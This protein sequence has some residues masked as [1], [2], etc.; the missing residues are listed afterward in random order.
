[1]Q[2]HF[3]RVQKSS[4]SQFSEAMRGSSY[5]YDKCEG[6]EQHDFLEEAR[7]MVAEREAAKGNAIMEEW[8]R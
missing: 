6:I 3:Y 7:K 8:D 1:M 5:D 4:L 2:Q